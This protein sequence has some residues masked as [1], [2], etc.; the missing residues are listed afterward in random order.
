MCL[1]YF[2]MSVV[3]RGLVKLLSQFGGDLGVSESAQGFHHH[4]VS[5]LADH[6]CWLGDI[7]N[8][9]CGKTNTCTK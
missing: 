4:F 7:T 2:D 1:T 5:I 6:Y 9:S 3:R 8:L